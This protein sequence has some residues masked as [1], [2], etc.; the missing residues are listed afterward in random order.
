MHLFPEL[1]KRYTKERLSAREAQRQ[2][3]FIAFGPV[4]FQ[5]ARIMLKLGIMDMIRDSENGL[6]IKEV[7][8]KADISEY[9]SKCLLEASLCIGILLVDPETG[10]FRI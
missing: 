1:Q 10:R 3:E 9:A 7:A 2:A 5:T 8:E 6:T 4:I